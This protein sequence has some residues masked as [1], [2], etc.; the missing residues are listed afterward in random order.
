MFP[1]IHTRPIAASP[2]AARQPALPCWSSIRNS[3]PLR[4]ALVGVTGV[5]TSPTATAKPR[6]HVK[7]LTMGALQRAR[8]TLAT[9]ITRVRGRGR[10]LWPDPGWSNCHKRVDTSPHR[11]GEPGRTATI[12]PGGTHAGDLVQA[13]AVPGRK[14]TA[15]KI[16]GGSGKVSVRMC[17]D[18][19]RLNEICNF[20]IFASPRSELA[21]ERRPS[22]LFLA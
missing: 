7:Q 6:N 1:E 4:Q 22:S 18:S 17:D 2:P 8:L 21:R 11:S 14:T 13:A 12:K 5:V 10:W 16:D 20:L 19:M 9:A 3:F 15:R